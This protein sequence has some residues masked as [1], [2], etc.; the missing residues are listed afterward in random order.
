MPPKNTY[1]YLNDEIKHVVVYDDQT[2]RYERTILDT[3]EAR[4]KLI[5][6]Y[7]RAGYNV[8]FE[9]WIGDKRYA[10]VYVS[11]RINKPVIMW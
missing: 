2:Y 9:K 4:N 10:L 3:E 7:N 1:D 6:G 11:E 5:T 8:C